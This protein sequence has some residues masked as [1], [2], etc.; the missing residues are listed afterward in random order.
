[1]R[2]YIY[3][4]SGVICMVLWLVNAKINTLCGRW[5]ERVLFMPTTICMAVVLGNF[6][7]ILGVRVKKVLSFLGSITLEIYLIHEKALLVYDT[8]ITKCIVGSLL[9]NASA[10]I[11]AVFLS[12]LLSDVAGKIQRVAQKS[13]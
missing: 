5:F 11:I 10:V 4:I 2:P 12:K 7:D 8:Y 3:I 13:S 1:M 9:S 6:L